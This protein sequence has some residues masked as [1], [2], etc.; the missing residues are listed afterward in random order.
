MEES[1]VGLT[2]QTFGELRSKGFNCRLNK[3]KKKERSSKN[4]V[5]QKL[6]KNGKC[7]SPTE[8]A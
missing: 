5:R 7:Y 6:S 1:C 2:R 8:T 4:I 3:K